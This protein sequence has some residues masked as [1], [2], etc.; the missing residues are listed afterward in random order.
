MMNRFVF[1]GQ[2]MVAGQRA[3]FADSEADPLADF[4]FLIERKSTC[5]ADFYK[6]QVSEIPG[7]IS[8]QLDGSVDFRFAVVGFG[9]RDNLAR[10]HIVTSG[11]RI[12]STAEHTTTALK[13]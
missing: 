7:L 12:F 2:Y 6:E 9:G 4:V 11:N 1:Q 3:T 8:R 5:P 13:T 10:P